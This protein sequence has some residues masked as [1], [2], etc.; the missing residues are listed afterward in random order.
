[1]FDSSVI[2][3]GPAFCLLH[4]VED[5]RHRKVFIKYSCTFGC[6]IGA[7]PFEILRGDRGEQKIC[8]EGR[9]HQNKIFGEGSVNNSPKWAEPMCLGT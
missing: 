8:A 1:M 9:P 2:S 7:F 5:L 3:C 6:F 4:F